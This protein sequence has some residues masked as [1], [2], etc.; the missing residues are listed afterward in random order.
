MRTL[1]RFHHAHAMIRRLSQFVLRMPKL[2]PSMTRASVIEW[3]IV[4]GQEISEYDL[5][6]RVSVP[7]LTKD[8]DVTDSAEVMDVEII[9]N[10][11]IH[12]ILVPAATDDVA[13][14]TPLVLLSD[15]PPNSDSSSLDR[16]LEESA[17]GKDYSECPDVLWQAYVQHKTPTCG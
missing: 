6:L 8:S 16:A 13:V 11:F 17:R 5:A 15:E 4:P 3:L 14:G 10:L 7:S 9:E 12:N 1:V 2:S